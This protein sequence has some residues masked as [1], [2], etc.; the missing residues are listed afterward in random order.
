[1][2][3]SKKVFNLMP[4]DG[5]V[6]EVESIQAKQFGKYLACC[7]SAA[8]IDYKD[9]S[10]SYLN[11]SASILKEISFNLNNL[12]YEVLYPCKESYPFWGIVYH[13][14]LESYP[15]DLDKVR[16]VL[17]QADYSVSSKIITIGNRT[18]SFLCI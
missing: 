3:V 12:Q 9:F 8:Q 10:L 2:L 11:T 16:L 13:T 15:N 7:L 14:F 5:T 1:M 4:F 17:E 18:Y 6:E